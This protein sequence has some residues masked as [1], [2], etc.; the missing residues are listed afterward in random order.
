MTDLLSKRMPRTLALALLGLALAGAPA[1]AEK[2][3]NGNGGGDHGNSGGDHGNSGSAHD[4]SMGQGKSTTGATASAGAASK[5]G[6]LNGFLH[7]SP[8]AIAHASPKS[9][10]GKV[11][12]YG[13]LLEA[14]V[15]PDATTKPTLQELQDALR[16]A[17]NK[18]VTADTV[19]A[20]NAKLL[21][22]DAALAASL[23]ASGKTAAD[24]NAELS[25]GL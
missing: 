3:G 11:A 8:T 23:T 4:G 2:G 9:A 20:V 17:S 15:S 6:K 24:L 5:Y 16:A 21:E 1:L 19:A 25:A 10:I 14:Y 7:A 22:V 13:K 18:P 12:A